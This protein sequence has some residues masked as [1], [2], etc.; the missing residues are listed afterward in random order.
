MNKNLGGWDGLFTVFDRNI[1]FTVRPESHRSRGVAHRNR[2]AG[3]ASLISCAFRIDD[4][5]T[6]IIFGEHGER[7]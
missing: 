7:R 1:S 6:I 2:H 4:A 3:Q 5:T